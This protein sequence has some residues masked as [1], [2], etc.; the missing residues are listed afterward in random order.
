MGKSPLKMQIQLFSVDVDPSSR[1][2]SLR[3]ENPKNEK[4]ILRY[5]MVSQGG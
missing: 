5:L 4:G 3:G 1:N 2:E